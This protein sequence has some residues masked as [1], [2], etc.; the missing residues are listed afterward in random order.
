MS[1]FGEV[2]TPQKRKW[3]ISTY[4]ICL[5]LLF[6]LGKKMVD[7]SISKM[8]SKT[9]VV[10]RIQLLSASPNTKAKKYQT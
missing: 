1:G 9:E 8:M 10:N 4:W 7:S 5:I 3:S 6:I 2:T